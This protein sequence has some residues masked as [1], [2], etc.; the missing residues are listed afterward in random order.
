MYEKRNLKLIRFYVWKLITNNVSTADL[1]C[2][3]HKRKLKFNCTL[4]HCGHCVIQIGCAAMY[5]YYLTIFQVFQLVFRNVWRTISFKKIMLNEHFLWEL[6]IFGSKMW[7]Q[8]RISQN[9]SVSGKHKSKK[10]SF[11]D[12]RNGNTSCGKEIFWFA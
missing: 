11:W 12:T 6:G 5:R 7:G 3:N 9:C 10:W 1:H 4:I 8:V 2:L